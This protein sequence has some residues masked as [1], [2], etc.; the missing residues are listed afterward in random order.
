MKNEEHNKCCNQEPKNC[1]SELQHFRYY[2]LD[3]ESVQR[4]NDDK[5]R[6][7]LAY[8]ALARWIFGSLG[9]KKRKTLPS[10]CVWKIREEY[11]SPDEQFTDLE[12]GE[13]VDSD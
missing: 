2:C 11:S 1:I 7:K 10:C 3:D 13:E 8:R 12:L 5:K 9:P 4:A 6:R